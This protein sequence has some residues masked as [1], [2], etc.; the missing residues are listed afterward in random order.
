MIEVKAKP[1]FATSRVENLFNAMKEQKFGDVCFTVRSRSYCL[2]M[3]VLSACSDFFMKNADN[4]GTIFSNFN[5]EVIDAILMYCYTGEIKIDNKDYI[6]FIELAKL[7]QLIN[8]VYTTIDV[9]TCLEVLRLSNDP[10]SRETAKNL[11]IKNF[12]TLHKTVDF[13]S[14]PASVVIEI[15]KSDKLSVSA[16]EV[17]ELVKLWVNFDDE[18]RRN[19]SRELLGCVNLKSLS[20]KFLLTEVMDFCYSSGDC[21]ALLKQ[22]I[23]TILP[24]YDCKKKEKIALV[25][26]W[27]RNIAKYIDVYDGEEK[28][29]NLSKDFEF[30]KRRFVSVLVDD[31]IL[32]IGG[33]QFP[34]EVDYIDL[35]TGQKHS[36]KPLC[37]SRYEFAAVSYHHKSSTDVYVIGGIKDKIL[38]SVERWNSKTK[39]W[40]MDIAPL[41]TTVC[42]HSSSIINDRIYVTGGRTEKL[43]N[44]IS[45]DKVQMY[46]IDSNSW[47]YRASMNQARQEHSSVSF[48]GKLFVA[49]GYFRN[50]KVYLSSVE[51]FDP[52]ANLWTNYCTLPI[53]MEGP[54]IIFFQNKLLCIGGRDEKSRRSNV[55]EYDVVNKNWISLKSLSKGRSHSTAI[56]IPY[57]SVI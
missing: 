57:H 9:T 23:Q 37:Q 25:G 2:H 30:E 27:C 39:S 10:V 32:I 45:I 5:D 12:K 44:L 40:E 11:T 18:H 56:I 33:D 53:P 51:S 34:N 43:G 24:N 38:A 28:Y 14:L 19:Y 8:A 6:K 21:I 36:L 48:K 47:S 55:W 3:V 17:F 46:S 31:W 29:W 22:E 54:T 7:L 41:L 1:N 42:A 20:M 16:E 50:T 4:L 26:G 35:K 15:L 49:G 52:D 13:L